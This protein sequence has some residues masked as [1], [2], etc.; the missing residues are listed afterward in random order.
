[1]ALNILLLEDD[2]NLNEIVKSYLL[3]YGYNVVNCF[4]GKECT[5]NIYK[6]EFDLYILDLMIPM[7]NGLDILKEIRGISN[8]PVL[9]I[10][11][12]D[13]ENTEIKAFE[14]GTDDYIR[15]PFSPNI[16][17]KRIEAI[18]RRANKM[19]CNEILFLDYKI[20]LSN[21]TVFYKDEDLQ[22]L[23]KEYELLKVLIQNKG[24]ILSRQKIL[25]KVW[26]YDY[27]GSDRVVDAHIKN[28]RKKLPTDL[29]VTVKNVGYCIK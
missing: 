16:L 5:D 17:L 2:K 23:M 27:F 18:F 8:N 4:D 10:T 26:G 25:D 12:I 24:S 21:Y 19:E 9:I 6:Q 14:Y 22:L 20:D 11:A 15:K 7:G 3:N 1:M 29:I 13:Y 28:L